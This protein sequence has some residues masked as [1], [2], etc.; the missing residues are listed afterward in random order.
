MGITYDSSSQVV[1]NSFNVSNVFGDYI[2]GYPHM[3]KLTNGDLIV[4]WHS[5]DIENGTNTSVYG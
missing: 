3:C 1:N 5:Y 2:Q 4:A